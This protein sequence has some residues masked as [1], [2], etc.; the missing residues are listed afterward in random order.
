MIRCGMRIAQR[1]VSDHKYFCSFEKAQQDQTNNSAL[2][3]QY[4]GSKLRCLRENTPK[5]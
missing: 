1:G 4:K 2:W 5:C 3:G